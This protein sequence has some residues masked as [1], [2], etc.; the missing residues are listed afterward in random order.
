MENSMGSMKRLSLLNKMSN[1]LTDFG[2]LKVKAFLF[3]KKDGKRVR[4]DVWSGGFATTNDILISEMFPEDENVEENCKKFM[5]LLE[6]MVKGYVPETWE[7][8]TV[9][10]IKSYLEKQT[11][12]SNPR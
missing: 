5:E 8:D 3:F 2:G 11:D 4:Y 12:L 7:Y 9:D 10:M 1:I 6:N